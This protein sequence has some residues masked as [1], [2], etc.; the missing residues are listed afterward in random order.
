MHGNKVV[1]YPHQRGGED[2][3]RIVIDDTLGRGHAL[4]T[5]DVDGDAA[6]EIIVGHSEP[7]SGEIKGP[8]VY[9]YDANADGTQW[10]KHVIDD[11]GMATEDAIAADL[12]GDGRTD[13][14]AGGR[15]THNVKLYWN[16][17]K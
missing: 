9:I 2:R 11:G 13:I 1:V 17:G 7:A 3:R 4:W 14:V 5:A 15:D 12:H 10:T 8:G 16:E 6:D